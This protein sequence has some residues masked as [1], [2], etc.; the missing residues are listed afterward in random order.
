MSFFQLIQQAL[1]EA[2]GGIMATALLATAAF[3]YNH[4]RGNQLNKEKGILHNL[5]RREYTKLIGRE[6]EFQKIIDA[7]TGRPYLIS[8]DGLGGIGKSTLALEIGYQFLNRQVVSH[9]KKLAKKHYYD[10]IIWV[11][12]KRYTLRKDGIITRA[13]KVQTLQDILDII[14]ITLK[15]ERDVEQTISQKKELARRELRKNH[16]LLIIDNLE[17]I[18]DEQLLEFLRELPEPTKALL[19][20]RY[21]TSETT[22][23]HLAGLPKKDSYILAKTKAEQRDI[24]LNEKQLERLY[25][26]TG[27]VP[28]A[29]VWTIAK[30]EDVAIDEAITSLRID[31]TSYIAEF[32]FT[33]VVE[34]I[35][36]KQS[37]HTLLALSLFSN[38][39]S[40]EALSYITD[41]PQS[42]CNNTLLE[43]ERLSLINKTSH[44]NFW[45]LPLTKEFVLAQL[46]SPENTK[47]QE[48][49]KHQYASYYNYEKIRAVKNTKNTIQAIH[50]ALDIKSLLVWNDEISDYLEENYKAIDR[51]I[52]ITRIFYMRKNAV[53]DKGKLNS[54]V[55]EVL[56]SQQNYNI[57]VKILWEEE[58]DKLNIPYPPDMIIFDRE[59]VHV[60]IGSGG[61]YTDFEIFL[62]NKSANPWIKKF[63]IL[64]KHAILWPFSRNAPSQ[65]STINAP[66]GSI[67]RTK[68]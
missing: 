47:L 52:S 67:S 4:R 7:L 37:Y 38:K 64:E 55:E 42:L 62:D 28:L 60:H 50:L 17:T 26:R 34:S 53:M 14:L 10:A 44:Q 49:L 32:C 58:L 2:L 68:N 20:T 1:P 33:E 22:N 8:I 31:D 56:A 46:E 35:K 40:K 51:G 48:K 13:Q 15:K 21:H 43:L 59:E 19:T 18:D 27:G 25:T 29:I 5:P 11:S 66:P 63:D 24:F 39:A 65:I 41:F 57:S 6:E 12:A 30:M 45:M 36:K 23:I 16:V 9:G 54:K 3:F 61:W